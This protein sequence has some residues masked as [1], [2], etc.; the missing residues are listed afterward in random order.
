M[1]ITGL[2]ARKI[3][4]S[5][6]RWTI[7]LSMS[8]GR[9]QFSASV[10]AGKSRGKYEA[11]QFSAYKSLK[12]FKAF[13]KKLIGKS[14][15]KQEDF[16]DFLTKV[17]GSGKSV[18]GV[19]L[20]LAASIAFS[21]LLSKKTKPKVIPTPMFNV[22]NGGLHAGGDL[23]I[24]EFMVVPLKF[25]SFSEQLEVGVKI[26]HELKKYLELKFGKSAVNVGDEGGF[27]P[28]MKTTEEALSALE[29]VTGSLGMLETVAFSVDCAASSY[30]SNKKY[31]L[32][33]KSF[34]TGEY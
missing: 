33:G 34:S 23:S 6:G 22:I 17:S 13:R 26:Y 9:K 21:R 29:E 2:S 20:T 32:D 30:F 14:F 5:R 8:S 11:T 27:A 31:H 4:D 16:D 1:K 19:D 15:S 18:F 10:P 28:P 25:D 24:Q 3:L 12:K 7:E